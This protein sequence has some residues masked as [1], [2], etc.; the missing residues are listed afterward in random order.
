MRPRSFLENLRD[1]LFPHAGNSY[2]PLIFEAA[3]V[4]ALILIIVVG[5][6]VFLS[7]AR[8]IFTETS[9]LSSVLPGVLVS[10]T[11]DD[12]SA[13]GIGALKEN[14]LLDAAAQEKANDMAA[15]G[16]FSHVTPDGKTP[17]YW[18]DR[19]GYKYVYAGEN[20]AVDFTDSTDVEKAWMNSP[21]H[22]ANIVKAQYTEV[23]IAT[24]NGTF[25]GHPAT[26]VV[27]FFGSP[28]AAAV[29]PKPTPTEETKPAP[30]PTELAETVAPAASATPPV[31]ASP[32]PVTAVLGTSS[33]PG[34]TGT[35][36]P[37]SLATLLGTFATSPSHT[38]VYLLSALTAVIAAV[39]ILAIFVQVRVQYLSVIAG[40]LVL[41]AVAGGSLYLNSEKV[42]KVRLPADNAAAAV[43]L[44]A[45][46]AINP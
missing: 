19:V 31:A 15:K 18:L 11:N 2:K 41:L 4:V 29:A 1:Y 40:G 16:Y 17:W 32:V 13:N 9:F 24:A 6:S 46:D 35:P 38:L 28:E 27:Q 45:V 22:R 42:A 5:Q 39:L 25:E 20:L 3:S 21:T 10:L 43:Y 12:R 37:S 30:A 44:G 26:F 8:Y 36:E 14:A 34:S 7:V 23:G 33:S